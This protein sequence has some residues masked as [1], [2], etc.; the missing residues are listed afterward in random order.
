[1]KNKNLEIMTLMLYWCFIIIVYSVI[2]CNNKKLEDPLSTYPIGGK[3]TYFA[4]ILDGW[5][6]SHFFIF[7]FAGIFYPDYF[8]IASILGIL[9]ELFEY[10][11]SN[12]G[13]NLSVLSWFKQ[14]SKCNALSKENRDGHWMYAKYSDIYINTFGFYIGYILSNCKLVK[15]IIKKN[16]ITPNNLSVMLTIIFAGWVYLYNLNIM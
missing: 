8:V 15:N 11:T 10:L 7:M 16:N 5:S 4:N 12:S 9:W 3:N 6:L 13:I 1:M 14:I 2:K